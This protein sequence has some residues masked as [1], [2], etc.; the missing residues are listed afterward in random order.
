MSKYAIITGVAS[1][2]GEC[3]AECF[4]EEGI[5][6]LGI[7]EKV[8]KNSRIEYFNCDIRKEEKIVN[9]INNIKEKTE[10]IDY[11]INCAGIFCYK[12]KKFN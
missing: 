8:P 11:L 10:R 6:V 9:I 3:I 7:D 5:H 2:I 1:G 12:R 4:I